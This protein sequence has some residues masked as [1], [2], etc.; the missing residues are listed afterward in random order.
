MR[1]YRPIPAVRRADGSISLSIHDRRGDV[2]SL[3]LPCG[4]CVGCRLSRAQAWAVRCR[5]EAALYDHNCFITLT[6]D[7]DNVPAH[8]SLRYADVQRFLKRL[9]KRFQGESVA[10][11]GRRPIRYF[12]TGEYGSTTL[13]PHYHAL[14]F[15]Y[16]FR[17]DAE[18]W[19]R[20]TY[21]SPTLEKL[22]P[23]GSCL[24]GPLTPESAAYTTR[25]CLKKVY[26][27]ENPDAYDAGVDP[28]T[29]E[30]FSRVPEFV[31]ASLK[32]GLGSWFFDKY[33]GDMYP[34]DACI[35]D[36][37]PVPVPMFYR[38]K[39]KE[40][41][42]LLSEEVEHRRF[43]RSQG[44]PVSERTP[45]RRAAAEAVRSAALAHFHGERGM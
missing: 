12:F 21:R 44:V 43:L 30:V 32:P 39:L 6:Y 31:S 15:N 8:G 37:R 7:D 26:A 35:Y 41:D 40:V 29:G 20:G 24:I 33:R 34:L 42:P 36:G 4:R 9:R 17:A 27:R 11:N 25:Y 10:P 28:A 5:H 2:A 1:C 14:I 18:P 3:E 38:R 13:R 22:W 16:S 19:G 23:L 45:E